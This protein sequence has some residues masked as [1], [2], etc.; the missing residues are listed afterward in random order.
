M[1]WELRMQREMVLA[2]AS[3]AW[4]SSFARG[5]D[6]LSADFTRHRRPRSS[7]ILIGGIMT[8]SIAS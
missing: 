5:D 4:T 6:P 2:V 1:N 3:W 7:S 8:D